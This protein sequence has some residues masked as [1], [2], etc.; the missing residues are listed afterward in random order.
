MCKS[1]HKLKN[2]RAFLVPTS[3]FLFLSC[4]LQNALDNIPTF[5]TCK[6]IILHLLVGDNMLYL[7]SCLQQLRKIR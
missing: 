7:G 4:T 1:K 2:N 3:I 5:A 6:G